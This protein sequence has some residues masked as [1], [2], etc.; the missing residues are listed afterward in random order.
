MVAKPII[1]ILGRWR[2]RQEDHELKANLGYTASS[3]FY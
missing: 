3:T 2:L 1:P